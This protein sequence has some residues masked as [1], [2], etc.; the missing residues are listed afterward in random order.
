M[1]MPT[2]VFCEVSDQESEQYFE[3]LMS[4]LD[5]FPLVSR[6]SVAD[7]EGVQIIEEFADV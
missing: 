4:I 5:C 7:G 1:S 6:M 2:D 3:R